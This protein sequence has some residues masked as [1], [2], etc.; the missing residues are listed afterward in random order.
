MDGGDLWE[1]CQG[2]VVADLSARVDAEATMTWVHERR[3]RRLGE[4]GRDL[5]LGLGRGA[6]AGLR[7]PGDWAARAA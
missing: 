2:H 3:Q 4:L 1:A 7:G 6:L 5:W